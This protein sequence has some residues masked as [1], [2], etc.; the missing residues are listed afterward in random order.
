MFKI[1][2][3]KLVKNQ[4][5]TALSFHPKLSPKGMNIVS[6]FITG[7]A[8]CL[9]KTS[10]LQWACRYPLCMTSNYSFY[11]RDHTE[12]LLC[13]ATSFSFPLSSSYFPPPLP[14]YPMPWKSSQPAHTALPQS[15]A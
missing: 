13:T 3:S 8:C 12:T 10:Y 2:N 5:Q 14:H 11:K 15:F 4:S 6:K 1:S 9:H 7:K